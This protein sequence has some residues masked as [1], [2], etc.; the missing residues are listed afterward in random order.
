MKVARFVGQKGSPDASYTEILSDEAVNVIDTTDPRGNVS[1]RFLRNGKPAQASLEKALRDFFDLGICVYIADELLDRE[2]GHDGWTRSFEFVMPV[3]EPA[4][5]TQHEK[6]LARLLGHLS[7][8]RYRFEWLQRRNLG[9]YGEHRRGVPTGYDS[10]CLFSGGVDSLLGAYDLLK[11]GKKVILCGHYADGISSKAQMDLFKMLREQFGKS[12]LLIQCYVART[13]KP[14]VSYPLSE[15]CEESHRPRSFLFLT[16][17]VAVARL[18]CVKEIYI[19]EN[20]LIALNAPLGISRVGT[21][22]TRTVHPRF[23]VDFLSLTHS[24]SIYDGSLTN[25]F[26][27]KSK[28]DMVRGAASTTHPMLLRSVSCAHAGSIRW[29][30]RRGIQHC[31]YCIPCLYRR[32]AFMEAGIDNPADYYCDVFG[33]LTKLKS[34]CQ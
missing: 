17:A 33:D 13:Q 25:P 27:L 5:W 23:L 32:V 2:R 15:K 12:V 24:L 21:L 14:T 1:V 34:N 7:G 4:L 20:G 30:G 10:V 8:D 6:R 11:A 31:G 28:T 29:T 22:S 16:T 18:A 9:G 26:L 19:P 3:Y